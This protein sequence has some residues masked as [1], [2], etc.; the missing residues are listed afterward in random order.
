VFIQIERADIKGFVLAYNFLY[1]MFCINLITRD[2]QHSC[3]TAN[4][5]CVP[6]LYLK[7]DTEEGKGTCVIE[8]FQLR[9]VRGAKEL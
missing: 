7:D 8:K 5:A 6:R 2:A 9:K 1:E 4:F 3:T